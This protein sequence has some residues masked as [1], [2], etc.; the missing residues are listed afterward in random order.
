MKKNQIGSAWKGVVLPENGLKYKGKPQVE[1]LGDVLERWD[2]P[3]R[4]NR[5]LRRAA[6]LVAGR[7]KKIAMKSI[8]KSPSVGM[9]T[10]AW[11][12][13]TANMAY[14]MVPTSPGRAIAAPSRGEII[15]DWNQNAQF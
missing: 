4:V 2:T 8:S 14:T 9:T 15:Y 6:L 3:I 10:T 7:A 11:S 12:G 1:I 5:G 13:S